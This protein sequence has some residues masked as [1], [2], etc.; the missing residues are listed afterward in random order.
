MNY[1]VSIGNDLDVCS[2]GRYEIHKIVEVENIIK[3]LW[4][5][6]MKVLR[7]I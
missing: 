7:A 2:N 6:A 1:G 4:L 3:H 5:K